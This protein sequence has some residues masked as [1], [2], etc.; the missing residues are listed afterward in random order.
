MWILVILFLVWMGYCLYWL[1]KS[2]TKN[3]LNSDDISKFREK[4]N[5]KVF[6]PK[7]GNTDIGFST[8]Y[9][10]NMATAHSNV[11]KKCGFSWS[12]SKKY[13]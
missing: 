7:C 12:P 9:G 6:C 10:L 4:A 11:C 8:S 5:G 3:K 13:Q 2:L 1:I